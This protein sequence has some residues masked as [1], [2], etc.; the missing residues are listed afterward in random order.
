VNDQ[1]TTPAAGALDGGASST[2][3][4]RTSS[5]APAART[6]P[7]GQHELDRSGASPRWN[8]EPDPDGSRA[9]WDQQQ[10]DR[11]TNNQAAAP[12][13]SDQAKPADGS[14]D[15]TLRVGNTSVTESELQEYLADRAARESGAL[16]T[17]ADPSGYE[18]K[19]PASFQPP[20]GVE[21]VLNEADPAFAQLR[22]W[23][24]AHQIPQSAFSD[25]L[26]IY[27]AKVADELSI[28][29]AAH[30]AEVAKLGAAGPQRIDAIA[31]WMKAKGYHVLPHTLWTEGVVKDYE[32]L[33][34]DTRSQGAA[35]YTGNGR[36][37][38]VQDEGRIA[39]YAGMSFEQRRQAQDVRRGR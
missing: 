8:A 29:K 25:L 14:A 26:G 15:K 31:R 10:R 7:P 19:L 6:S 38:G 34:A 13:K 9:Q 39:G 28:G 5:S 36:D 1:S 24:H 35:S 30:S 22:G 20:Q 21:V 32:K 11:H 2:P 18:I 27:G 3:A 16:Q 17:P 4:A 37:N 23:A 33:M 12:V